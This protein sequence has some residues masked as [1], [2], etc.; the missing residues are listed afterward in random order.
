MIDAA[1]K[2]MREI[3]AE[4]ATLKQGLLDEP[5]MTA[6]TA[7]I[8]SI[9]ERTNAAA[10]SARRLEEGLRNSANAINN[11][12]QLVPRIGS[13]NRVLP[14]AQNLGSFETGAS[15]TVSVLVPFDNAQYALGDDATRAVDRVGQSLAVLAAKAHRQLQVRVDGCANATGSS[16]FNEWLSG[17]RADEVIAELKLRYPSLDIVYVGHA[18]GAANPIPG[19]RPTDADNRR[20]QFTILNAD[21]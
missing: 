21:Q 4:L 13:N 14:G 7:A 12:D 3:E 6:A 2:E 1:T 10:D 15:P 17:R 16:H 11:L 8:R 20:V 19:K 18:N 5:A 9:D